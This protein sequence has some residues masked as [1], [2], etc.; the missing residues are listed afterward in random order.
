VVVSLGAVVALVILGSMLG[1]WIDG[2]GSSQPGQPGQGAQ[3]GY[4]GP[5]DG[6]PRPPLGGG[7]A[8]PGGPRELLVN[9]P[10]GDG[11]TVFVLHGRGWVP[12]QQ[13]TVALDGKVS[14]ATPTA[15]LAGT[16]NYAI[17]QQHEFFP[18]PVPSGHH[19]AAASAPGAATMQ[20]TFDI[21][22]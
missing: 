15:D 4:A 5:P 2:R 19:T 6:A 12:G 9:Q 16:F 20:V 10:S 11:Y 22:P 7:S 21:H 18:G 3:T 17:N 14:R 1:A 13:V 8:R